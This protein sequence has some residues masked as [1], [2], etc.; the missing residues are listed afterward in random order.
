M[1]RRALILTFALLA[2]SAR[3]KDPAGPSGLLPTYNPASEIVTWTGKSWNITDNRL[4]HSRFEKYLS[5]PSDTNQDTTEHFKILSTIRELLSPLNATVQA[6]EEAFRL[7]KKASDY[8]ADDL[9]SDAIANQVYAAWLA[10][11]QTGFLQSATETLEKERKR[12]EWNLRVAAE[13]RGLSYTPSDEAGGAEA[14]R[15]QEYSVEMQQIA[16]RLA[17]VNILL[18]SSRLKTDISR[19]QAKTDFQILIVQLFLQRRFHHVHIATRFYRSIFADGSSQQLKFGEEAQNLFSKATGNPPTLTTLDS[20]CGQLINEAHDG[21]N[22]FRTLLAT[23]ELAGAT[24]RLSEAFLIGEYLTSLD[25][26]SM[27]EKHRALVFLQKSNHLLSALDAKDFALAEKIVVEL[28]ATAKDFDTTK[29]TAAI[30]TAKTTAAMHLAKARNAALTGDL[31]TQEAELNT[32]IEIWPTNPALAEVAAGIYREENLHARALVEF[33]QL[34]SQ[35]RWRQ[36]YEDRMRFIPALANVPEK[37]AKLE[38]IIEKIVLVDRTVDRAMELDKRGE[39]AGAWE[40]TEILFRRIPEEYPRLERLHA[41]L[42]PRAAD[43]V[44]AIQT[45]RDLEEKGE[46]GS[47]LFWYLQ[48]QLAYPSGELAKAGIQRLNHLIL[49]DSW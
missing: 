2:V 45:A 5:T 23:D 41:E 35:R 44:K 37:Q 28:N 43:Y 48:A 9:L 11:K 10:Q 47:A 33:N 21:V 30:E 14:G 12:L 25:V 8:H 26:V 34:V 6:R 3:G 18:K 19:A 13:A 22:A 1:K 32:A 49:P 42:A 46:R 38:E 17:E 29:A 7:L 27:S 20:L 39:T 16:A 15:A 24:A 31:E 36:I 4:F 40:T